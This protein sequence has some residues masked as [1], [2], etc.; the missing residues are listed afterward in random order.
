MNVMPIQ[1][2]VHSAILSLGSNIGARADNLNTAINQLG[3]FGVIQLQS[4]VYETSPWGNEEQAF[5][6]NQAV[7]LSTELSSIEL[8]DKILAIESGMG[9]VRDK[10]WESRIIDI[11]IVFFG[12]QVIETDRLIVP[13]PFM[14]E[15]A[16]VLIPLLEICPNRAHPTLQKTVWQLF[17]ECRDLSEVY[18]PDVPL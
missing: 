1:K 6:L 4:S 10:K 9:R 8:L 15:R 12:D 18:L 13:H 11:D 14:H 3:D 16:F 5:F 2:I 17:D 7:E